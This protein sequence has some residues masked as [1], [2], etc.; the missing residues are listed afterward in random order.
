MNNK[1][2]LGFLLILALEV[3]INK[4]NGD[5]IGKNEDRPVF[6]STEKDRYDPFMDMHKKG[7]DFK[8]N[9]NHQ[10]DENDDDNDDEDEQ[11]DNIKFTKI[12]EASKNKVKKNE[13][14]PI[15]VHNQY[16][17]IGSMDQMRPSYTTPYDYN[18]YTPSPSSSL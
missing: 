1:I 18:P 7:S 6:I 13:D 15:I 2:S 12:N 3:I 9:E 8:L 4:T 14:K 5:T 17:Y 11:I 16:P 10:S